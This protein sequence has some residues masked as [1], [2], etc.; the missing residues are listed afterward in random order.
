MKRVQSDHRVAGS[1]Q[2]AQ[3]C[4]ILRTVEI[5][6]LTT[7]TR[8][9]GPHTRPIQTLAV[10]ED[11][12]MLWFF[13]DRSS[14]KTREVGVDRHVTLGYSKP[15]KGLFA[16]VYGTARVLHDPAQAR[17]LWRLEQRAFYPHGPT[18]PHLAILRV[19]I[20]RAEYWI[21]PGRLSY[22]AAAARAALSGTARRVIGENCK[23]DLKEQGPAPEI[24]T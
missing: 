6:L 2:L 5:A 18:D 11:T 13:T 1:E 22:W 4:A 10:D 9:E 17:R 19:H 3:L 16:V 21:T 24:L 12:R 14:P 8:R 15:A 20:E 7:T 23:V